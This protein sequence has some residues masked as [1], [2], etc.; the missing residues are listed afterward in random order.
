M[1][2]SAAQASARRILVVDDHIDTAQALKRLL[3]AMGFQV[4]SADSF[5]SA[6]AATGDGAFDL[7]LTDIQL[8]DGDGLELLKELRSRGSPNARGLTLSGYTEDEEKQRSLAAGYFAHL[9]KPVDFGQ[10]LKMVKELLA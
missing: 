5:A 10:L 6:I 1:E 9:A 4:R 3:E 8:V 7:L 2:T